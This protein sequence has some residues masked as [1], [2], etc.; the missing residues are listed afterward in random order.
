M[1]FFANSSISHLKTKTT[2]ERPQELEFQPDSDQFCEPL[3]TDS[4]TEQNICSKITSS[5]KRPAQEATKNEIDLLNGD[6]VGLYNRQKMD[7]LTIEEQEILKAK[8]RKLDECKKKLKN[9]QD[10]Q[11]NQKKFRDN[12]REALNSAVV[13]DP[14][15][16]SKLKIKDSGS[17]GR[18]RLEETQPLLLSEIVRIAR[19]GSAAH[20]KR[21]DEI[22]RSILTLDDLTEQL[23]KDGFHVKRSSVYLRLQPKRSSSHQGKRHID[24]VPVRLIRAQNDFHKSHPDQRLCQATIRTMD[25]LASLL[26]PSEVCYISQDDKARYL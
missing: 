12:R 22:Y 18:P 1:Q 19:H 21:Q 25:E 7:M 16:K 4:E 15:L 5:A 14:N 26:G 13:A 3:L 6:L 11:Q 2:I 20:E 24:T 10:R 23:T 17:A 8:K 9:L